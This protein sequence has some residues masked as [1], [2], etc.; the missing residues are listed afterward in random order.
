M[1]IITDDYEYEI[2]DAFNSLYN[3]LKRENKFVR[4][5]VETRRS[6]QHSAIEKRETND[7]LKDR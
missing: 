1:I 4:V 7:F 2:R 5:L 3:I 6:K